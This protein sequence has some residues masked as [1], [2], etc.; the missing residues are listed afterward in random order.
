[1]A[2]MAKRGG[3]KTAPGQKGKKVQA[4]TMGKTPP[5]NPKSPGGKVQ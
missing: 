4:H 5:K 1:M 2:K 3:S